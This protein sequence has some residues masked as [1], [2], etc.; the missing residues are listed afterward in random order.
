MEWDGLLRICFIRKNKTLKA[1]FKN[2]KILQ[3]LKANSERF[4]EKYSENKM[5]EMLGKVELAE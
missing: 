1:S 4:D 2:K 5:I 3:M